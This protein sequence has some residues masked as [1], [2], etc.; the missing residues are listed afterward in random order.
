MQTEAAGSPDSTG[1]RENIFVSWFLWQFYEMPAFLLRVWGNY[2]LFATN[3]FSFTLLLKTF[4]SP[5]RR[6]KWKYPIGF[7]VG[8]FF[9]TLISNSFSRFLGALMR[10]FLIIAGILLQIFV[11]LAG[12]IIFIAWLV[13][14]LIIIFGILFAFVY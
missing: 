12:L 14:P 7:D 8:E 9:S 2:F 11:A 3:Y 10:V 4:F 5:W 6:Y 1:V 13:L